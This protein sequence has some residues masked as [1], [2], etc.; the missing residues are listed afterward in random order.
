MAVYSYILK[1]NISNFT[2]MMAFKTLDLFDH[3]ISFG[4][5]N[6][7]FLLNFFI[8]F[9]LAVKI[10]T[11]LSLESLLVMINKFFSTKILVNRTKKFN[12]IDTMN[13][14]YF[15]KNQNKYLKYFLNKAPG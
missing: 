2:Q 5:I 10:N 6:F 9:L 14:A 11:L 13:Y 3:D 7:I 8:L 12:K 1:L 15:L 4:E